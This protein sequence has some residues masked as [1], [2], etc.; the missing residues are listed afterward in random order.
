MAAALHVT[1]GDAPVPDIAPAAGVAPG[2]VLVW[3]D[4]LH[5]GPVP[6]GLDP[7]ELARVRARHLSERGWAPEE[8]LLAALQARDARLAAHPPD[9]EVVLWFEDDLFDAL[10]LAQIADRLTGRPGPVTLVRLPHG[11]RTDLPAAF[12]A[13]EPYAPDPTPFAALRSP[14]PRAWTAHGHMSRLLEELPDTRT[15]LGRLEREILQALADGP[16]E[17]AALFHRVAE[18]ERPPWLG[19]A[20]LFATAADLGPLTAHTDGHWELTA[21]G[22]AVLAGTATRPPYDRWIGGVHLAPGHPRWAYDAT[23]RQ[24]TRLD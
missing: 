18:R 1:N 24:A 3:L 17:P 22:R 15:G 9:A 20:S 8:E 4:V 5:D 13:R 23:T 21:D 14:D 6:A 7:E 10:Q 11:P 12:A 2:E 16:L 19:D